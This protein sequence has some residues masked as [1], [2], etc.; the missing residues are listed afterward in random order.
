MLT[1]TLKKEKTTKHIHS[2]SS[3]TNLYQFLFKF[4]RLYI[5]IV[6]AC[7][8]VLFFKYISWN[9][10]RLRLPLQELFQL[11]TYKSKKP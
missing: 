4:V 9:Y 11:V 10:I 3:K 2:N 5:I 8:L 7:F 6:L 1:N